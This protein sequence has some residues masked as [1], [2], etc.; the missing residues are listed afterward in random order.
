MWV[1]GFSEAESS[2]NI[3]IYKKSDTQKWIVQV[4]FEISLHSKDLGILLE[5]KVFLG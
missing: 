5:I 2:F 1:T 4:S 3:T